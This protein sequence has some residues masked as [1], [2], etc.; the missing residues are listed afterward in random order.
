VSRKVMHRHAL[1]L[2]FLGEAYLLAGRIDEATTAAQEALT[3]AQ[4]RKERGHE[5]YAL[6]LLGEISA[7]GGIAEGDDAHRYY[8]LASALA[9]ELEMRPLLSYCHLGLARRY[10]QLGKRE[11]AQDHLA[12]ATTMFQEMAMGLWLEQAHAEG[13][14][15]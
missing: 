8:T 2:G 4:Q 6:R 5:A 9:A 7:R 11:E 1:T 14:V 15:S 10:R 3:L 13:A 12:V